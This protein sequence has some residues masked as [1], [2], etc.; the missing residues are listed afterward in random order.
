VP[1][2]GGVPLPEGVFPA[3]GVPPVGGVLFLLSHLA[4]GE[5]LI[6]SLRCSN[7]KSKEW[8]IKFSKSVFS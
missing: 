4:Y 2:V 6:I 8:C 7:M 5:A 1:L 3:G